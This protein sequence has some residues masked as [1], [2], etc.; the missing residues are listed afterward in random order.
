MFLQR[1]RLILCV[2]VACS[3][4]GMQSLSAAPNG[5][6]EEHYS[7]VLPMGME[8][9]ELLPARSA[10]Y[11]FAS[12][13]APQLEGAHKV[14]HGEKVTLLGRD[15]SEVAEFPSDVTFRVTATTR[16]HLPN[17]DISPIETDQDVNSFLLSLKFRIR[18]VNGLESHYIDPLDVGLIGV[19]ADIPYNER[20]YR[21]KVKLPHVSMKDR[22]IFEVYDA[23]GERLSKFYYELV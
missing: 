13:D 7:P 14:R 9:V 23:K 21:V 1:N 5:S 8:T 12:A 18:V 15:G 4:L 6:R 16:V 3:L 22:V 19:P 20:I 10:V 17:P 2:V 11:L